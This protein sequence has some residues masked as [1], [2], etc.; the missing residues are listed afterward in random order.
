[1]ENL[2]LSLTPRLIFMGHENINITQVSHS[3]EGSGER[4][5]S[6]QPRPFTLVS[7]MLNGA[8]HLHLENIDSLPPQ[9]RRDAAASVVI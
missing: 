7:Y 4:H 9:G 1:M 3:E 5:S 2:V 8:V 6:F